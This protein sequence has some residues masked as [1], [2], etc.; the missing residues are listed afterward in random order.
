MQTSPQ[1]HFG[2]GLLSCIFIL[3]K[4]YLLT[5]PSVDRSH[6]DSL[7][8]IPVG[9]ILEKGDGSFQEHLGKHMLS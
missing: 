8:C 4:A 1:P 5:D 2:S 7:N 9:I 3:Q 6:R